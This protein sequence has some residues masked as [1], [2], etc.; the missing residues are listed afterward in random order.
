MGYVTR[1]GEVK[2]AYEIFV[3]KPD[4]KIPLGRHNHGREDNI[5]PD[6]K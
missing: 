3:G 5:K 4:G 6:L 1:N 2:N